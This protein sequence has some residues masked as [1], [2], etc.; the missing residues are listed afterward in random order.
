MDLGRETRNT[1]NDRA[2][3]ACS[4][5]PLL[6]KGRCTPAFLQWT[7]NLDTWA[8]I[9]TF[10]D[11]A[12]PTKSYINLY[13]LSSGRPTQ[14]GLPGKSSIQIIKSPICIIISNSLFFWQLSAPKSPLDWFT[15]WAKSPVQ[16]KNNGLINFFVDQSAIWTG[17]CMNIQKVYLHLNISCVCY[18]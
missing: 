17:Y 16:L 11:L 14:N 18:T 15:Q 4:R 2:K 13:S 12:L 5:G 6:E 8:E 10:R 9:S 3:P 7:H 1:C